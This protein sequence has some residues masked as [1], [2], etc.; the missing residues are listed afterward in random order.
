LILNPEDGQATSDSWQSECERLGRQL[1]TSL[2]DFDV[3]VQ[4]LVTEAVPSPDGRSR[5]DATIFSSLLISGL[6]TGSA[7]AAVGRLWDALTEWMKRRAGCRA[8]IKLDDGSEFHFE[9]LT[10]DDAIK[11]LR[12]RELSRRKA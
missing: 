7:V 5:G 8:V 12:S 10:K 6:E 2:S 1:R 11:L 3:S 4:P 9:N